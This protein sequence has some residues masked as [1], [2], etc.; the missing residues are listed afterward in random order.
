MV[1][2]YSGTRRRENKSKWAMLFARFK[3]IRP[4]LALR[5]KRMASWLKYS[6]EGVL[7]EYWSDNLLDC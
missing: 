3:L 5:V 4:L 1:L 6:L 7:R 2:W